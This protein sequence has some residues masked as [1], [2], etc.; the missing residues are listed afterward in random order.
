MHI[1]NV[2]VI[3][4]NKVIVNSANLKNGNTKSCGCYNKER[5]REANKKYNKYDLSGEYGIG[6]TFKNEKFYFDLCD[7]NLIKEHCWYIGANIY[8]TTRINGKLKTMHKLIMPCLNKYVIDH[9][10]RRKI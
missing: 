1:I 3:V 7:Y 2:C 9:I 8:M 4:G 6:Y 10:N 5:M